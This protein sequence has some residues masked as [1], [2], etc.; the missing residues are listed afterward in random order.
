MKEIGPTNLEYHYITGSSELDKAVA[1]L[2]T[3]SEIGVDTEGDSLY[4]YEE[5]VSLIQI[6]GGEVNYI[7]DP[8][9]LDTVKPL[10][11]LFESPSILKIFHGS[12]YDLVSLKRDFQFRIGPIF[13]T[14]LAARAVGIEK[15]SLQ[16]LLAHFFHVSVSKQFQKSNWKLRPLPKKQLDY[17]SQDTAYLIPLYHLLS[18]A[19]KEKGRE[20]QIQEEC[21]LMEEITWSGKPFH[22]DDYLRIKGAKTLPEQA[23]KILRELN[24]V[25]N[26]IAKKRN[27]PSFKVISIA[28]LLTMSE[29]PPQDQAALEK[30]FPKKNSSVIRN[31]TLWLDAIKEGLSTDVPLPEKTRNGLPP[32]T[33]SQERLLKQLKNWRNNQAKEEGVEPAMVITSNTLKEIARVAPKTM[34]ALE[35]VPFIRTW[36]TKRYGECLLKNISK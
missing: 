1:A 11:L 36:Q 21:R 19:V 22:P 10:G 9:L 12:D 26:Q 15:F 28:S 13:D 34:E 24:V 30:L 32:L 31:R 14:A 5:Q 4:S 2:S 6:T 25:R 17:A 27:M 20:D 33:S 8:L 29:N 7:F 23:Q 3:C 35:S 16:N 18:G